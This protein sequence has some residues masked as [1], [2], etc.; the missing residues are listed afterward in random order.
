MHQEESTTDCHHPR[1]LALAINFLDAYHPASEDKISLIHGLRDR[2]RGNP[3]PNDVLNLARAVD[4]TP[5]VLRRGVVRRLP[6]LATKIRYSADA[7]RPADPAS[8][9]TH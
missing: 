4:S 8:N 2:V 3:N 9:P 7:V 5:F 1:S 6:G